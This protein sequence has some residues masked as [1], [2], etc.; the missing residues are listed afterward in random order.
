M[1]LMQGLRAVNTLCCSRL[2]ERT[3][4]DKFAIQLWKGR[5][6]ATTFGP[7]SKR[8]ICFFH[9]QQH[10]SLNFIWTRHSI[11]Y[12]QALNQVP[13]SVFNSPGGH[14][15]G[16]QDPCPEQAPDCVQALNQVHT[17]AADLQVFVQWEVHVLGHT[18]RS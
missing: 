4:K 18:N 13:S 10:A 2:V 6:A 1:V 17:C 9:Q 3:E 12:V 8:N 16:A 15:E 7:D 11:K 14:R 5:G